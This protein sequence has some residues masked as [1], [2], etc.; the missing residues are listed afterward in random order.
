M[1][2]PFFLLSLRRNRMIRLLTIAVVLLLS[3]TADAQT[4]RYN[5][6]FTFSEKIFAD[7]IPIEYDHDQLYLPVEIKGQR[8]R[9]KLDTG[10]AMAVIYDDSPIRNSKELGFIQSIDAT[11]AKR[12]VKVVAL[13]PL[14]IG[15]LTVNNYPACVHRRMVRRDREDGIIGFDLFNKGL[16]AKIDTRN[17]VMIITDQ[18]Q[19]LQ[20]MSGEILRYQLKRFVPYI[21]ISPIAGEEETV[22]FDTGSRDIYTMN[23]QQFDNFEKK[24]PEISSLVEGRGYGSIAIGHF[25][26]EHKDEIVLLALPRLLLNHFE[27]RD[28]H[29]QSFQGNSHIGASLLRYGIVIISPFRKQLIFQSYDDPS[30]CMVS[31]PQ[32][33]IAIVPTREGKP[34][35]G[36]VWEQS[37]AYKQG[38]RTGDIIEKVDGFPVTDFHSFISRSYVFD[39]IYAFTLRDAQGRP[40]EVRSTMPLLKRH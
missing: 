13:P 29:C 34:C 27:L 8:L 35:V 20:E 9:F 12:P 18:R 39:R 25:G 3:I 1:H 40:K 17:G 5:L 33:E 19:L 7:T 23:K 32:L 21:K 4:Y 37:E 36:I 28:I 2:I 26:A 6:K 11:G 22:L 15:R 30:Y 31:N 16:A 14:R 38:F 10:S 24:H